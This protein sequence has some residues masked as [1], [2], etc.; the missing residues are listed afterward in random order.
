MD[1]GGSVFGG[2]AQCINVSGY[3][4]LHVGRKLG[5]CC[6]LVWQKEV[7]D[8]AAKN[9]SESFKTVASVS[10]VS[11]YAANGGVVHWWIAPGSKFPERKSRFL[12]QF[13]DSFSR[14]FQ[15]HD[16][17]PAVFELLK[18]TLCSFYKHNKSFI[19]SDYRDL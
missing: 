16:D 1:S 4:V 10:H 3:V 19:T 5:K 9:I 8:L 17:Y 11:F 18:S 2:K 15:F 13:P 12:P 6:Q 14:Q 7:R